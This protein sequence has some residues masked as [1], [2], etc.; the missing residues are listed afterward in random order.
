MICNTKEFTDISAYYLKYLKDNNLYTE[1]RYKQGIL[2]LNKGKPIQYIIGNV[3]FYGNIIKVNEKVL[4]PRFET[5]LLVEKTAKYIKKL[6]SNKQLELID[7]GTGSGCIAITLKKIF[8][9]IIIDAIDISK[10][11]LEVAKNNA[12]A[13]NVE[14]NFRNESMLNLPNKKYDIIISNPPYIAP[15]E[16]IM[17][18]VKNNEPLIALYAE[19]DGLFYYEQIIKK[20]QSSLN[21]KYLICFEIGATQADKIKNIVNLYLDNVTIIVEKDYQQKDR[22]IFIYKE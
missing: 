19:N 15:N 7:I 5:E 3:D 14:I 6:F 22:Y 10:E 17:D 11:A 9:S 2:E 20:W 4:I 21:D 1:E 8:P 13:N 12:D 18:I 16:S